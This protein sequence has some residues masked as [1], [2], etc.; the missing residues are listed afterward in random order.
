MD[1]IKP[2][3]RYTEAKRLW[4][5]GEANNLYHQENIIL[6]VVFLQMIIS[7][8]EIKFSTLNIFSPFHSN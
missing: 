1:F 4:F 2:H 8:L 7:G 3:P 6:F 5:L